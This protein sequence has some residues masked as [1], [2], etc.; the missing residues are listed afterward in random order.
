MPCYQQR[1]NLPAKRHTAYRKPDGGLYAEH[2]MGTLGFDGPASL[3][4]HLRRPTQ[5]LATRPFGPVTIEEESDQSV[6]MRHFLTA[7]IDKTASITL[8]RTPLL[9]NSDVIVSL[10][11]PTKTDAFFFR[12]GQ[13]DQVH[14]ISQG[15]GIVETEFGELPYR[16]GDYIVIP[17][18]I[19]HR[20]RLEGDEHAVL[21]FET[22]SYVRFPSR[23][24]TREGQLMEHAPFCERDIR[25]PEN[26]VCQDQTGEFKVLVKQRNLLTEI[27]LDHHPCDVIAWDGCYYPW[28]LS[29]HDFEP[30][31]GS[32]HQPPPV[33]QTLQAD[34]FVLCS[35]TPRMLDYHPEAVPAPYNHSNVMSDEV[36]YYANDQFISRSGAGFGSLTLHPAGLPHG[37]QPGKAEAS[38]GGKRTEELAVMIDTFH[39][40]K[41]AAPALDFEDPAYGQSWIEP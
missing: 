28:A 36:I 19:V 18:G 40:L 23:Y 11:R 35:F 4:Y 1:G 31:T 5:I 9:F 7:Q 13:A 25:A 15:Q 29:I 38:I 41:V 2:L 34:Q 14:Y 12:N 33:H 22:P 6:R 21:I 17:R 26:L 3:L 27:I 24:L 10:V 32:L 16:E 30:I 39:P 8:D 37:P 20:F